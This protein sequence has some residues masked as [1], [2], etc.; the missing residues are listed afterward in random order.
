MTH[1]R[2]RWF[3]AADSV[4]ASLKYAFHRSTWGGE[5]TRGGVRV[6]ET[7]GEASD[8]V[9]AGGIARRGKVS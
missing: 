7:R 1:F 3:S 9:A 4:T 5:M 2:T 6:E 8:E